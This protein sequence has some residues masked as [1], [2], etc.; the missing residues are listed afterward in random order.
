MSCDNVDPGDRR[1]LRTPAPTPRFP[2]ISPNV[3]QA[4]PTGVPGKPGFGLLGWKRGPWQ[5]RFWLAGV[6]AGSLAS[7]VLACWGGSG[8]PGKPGFGLLAW[9]VIQP[10]QW[11]DWHLPFRQLGFQTS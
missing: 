4:H 8:V 9:K 6:E 2:P 1:A 5:A 7:P 11:M 10:C 3:T